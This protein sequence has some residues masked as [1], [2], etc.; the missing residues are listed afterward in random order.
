[1]KQEKVGALTDNDARLAKTDTYEVDAKPHGHG[2][3]HALMYST[4]T[5]KKWKEQ[6]VKWIVF[7]QVEDSIFS[8]KIM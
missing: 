7:F 1:M 5:A 6:G 8:H 3:V 4:G 2:D